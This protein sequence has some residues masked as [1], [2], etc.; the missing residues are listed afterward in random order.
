M[1]VNLADGRAEDFDLLVGADGIW[2][3]IRKTLVGETKVG[4]GV[5]AGWDASRVWGRL[6]CLLKPEG[7]SA[8]SLL[9]PS[10]HLPSRPPYPPNPQANYSGYTCYTGISDFTPPDIEI[11]GYR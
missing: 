5:A 4:G 1:R 8:Q 9:S 6:S 10:H 2:S 11:V 3:R 7:S